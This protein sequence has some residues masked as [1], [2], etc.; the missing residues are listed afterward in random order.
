M[1]AL[2]PSLIFRNQTAKKQNIINP[3]KCLSPLRRERE[4]A[5][6]H[7]SRQ[8]RPARPSLD[9]ELLPFSRR[10]APSNGRRTCAVTR[11]NSRLAAIFLPLTNRRSHHRAAA[12]RASLGQKEP[13]GSGASEWGGN[14]VD[15]GGDILENTRIDVVFSVCVWK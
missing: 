6:P 9:G 12:F 10:C 15:G 2:S 8:A 13:E 1:V 14:E 5:A 7:G 11:R 4:V 3:S